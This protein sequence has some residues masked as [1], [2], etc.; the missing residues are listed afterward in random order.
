MACSTECSTWKLGDPNRRGASAG[1]ST[2]RRG[3]ISE[4]CVHVRRPG[5]GCRDNCSRSESG[6]SSFERSGKRR[7]PRSTRLPSCQLT[8][9]IRGP[10]AGGQSAAACAQWP[11]PRWFRLTVLGRISGSEG[12]PAKVTNL[13]VITFRSKARNLFV[14]GLTR[15]LN[16]PAVRRTEAGPRK[17]PRRLLQVD[18]RKVGSCQ[19][20]AINSLSWTTGVR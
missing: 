15:K 6:G 10:T 1:R 2:V 12:G 8:A 18:A 17:S 9:P 20:E 3:A 4:H 13:T 5:A 16:S 7:V 19:L 14:S 11:L